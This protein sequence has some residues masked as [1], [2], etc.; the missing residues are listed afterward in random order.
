[1]R[2]RAWINEGLRLTP[3]QHAKSIALTPELN[4]LVDAL[5]ASGAYNSASEGMRDGSPAL[6]DRRERSADALAE[7]RMRVVNGF[8]EADRGE[9]AESS[10]EEAVRRAFETGLARAGR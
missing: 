6:I 9:Y 4:R 1:M 5:V 2:Y 8:A 3:A 10:G 7:I